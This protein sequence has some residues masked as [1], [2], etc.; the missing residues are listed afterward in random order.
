[1][2]SEATGI[3]QIV[4]ECCR[5]F[6]GVVDWISYFVVYE[7]AFPE[8]FF[9][10]HLG[11]AWRKK[12]TS[13]VIRSRLGKSIEGLGYVAFV[14]HMHPSLPLLSFSIANEVVE[15]KSHP[16]PSPAPRATYILSLYRLIIQC[17]PLSHFGISPSPRDRHASMEHAN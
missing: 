12:E 15:V 10:C 7:E 16:L 17:N 4:Q 2:I 14:L 1:M 9:L 11:N 6:E 5:L 8:T 3:R 13:G